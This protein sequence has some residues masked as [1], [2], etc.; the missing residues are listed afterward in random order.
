MATK[1]VLIKKEDNAPKDEV[2]NEEVLESH[3][4]DKSEGGRWCD[5]SDCLICANG[6]F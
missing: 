3:E 2:F 5:Y 4:L 6:I 1:Q